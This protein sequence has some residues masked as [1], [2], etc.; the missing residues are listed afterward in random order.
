MTKNAELIKM[1][2]IR[3]TD[4]RD[5]AGL[6]IQEVAEKTGVPQLMITGESAVLKRLPPEYAPLLFPIERVMK[7]KWME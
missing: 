6:S 1:I 2:A 5:I 7:P 4:L 3:I